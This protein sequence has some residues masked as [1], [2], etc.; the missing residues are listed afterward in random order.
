M[1]AARASRGG[2]PQSSELMAPTLRV[3]RRLG[4][5]ASNDELSREVP[6][7]LGLAEQ[8]TSIIHG[9][10]PY[11]EVEYRLA[12][13]RTFL[14]RDGLINNSRRGIWSLTDLGRT[15]EASGPSAEAPTVVPEGREPDRPG[16]GGVTVDISD[17]VT[18]DTP[19]AP[20]EWQDRLLA[21][22]KAMDPD[23]FER[24]CQRVL[25]ESGFVEV[26]VTGKSG[27]G[28]IDGIGTIRFADLISFPVVFQCK[29]WNSIVASSVVRDFRGAMA[30]RADRGIIIT[31]S[32][33][34]RDAYWEASR[35]GVPPIDLIDGEKLVNKVKELGLG[36]RTEMVE[37]VTIESAW[38][39]QI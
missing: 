13:A 16:G 10:G 7:D 17:D 39:R 11:T 1:L 12:W 18:Q 4:G 26:N 28:G 22:L 27:D 9:N 19:D 6:Q 14:K 37:Q 38:F 31:T 2:I 34:T 23:A 30:G 36:V 29:R 8:I 25:R 20:S 3:I 5:S 21:I 32:A 24:L 35:A 33:F 15:T